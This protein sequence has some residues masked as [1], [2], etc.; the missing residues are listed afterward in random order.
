MKPKLDFNTPVCLIKDL[1]NAIRHILEKNFIEVY[2]EVLL[3]DYE[4]LTKLRNMGITNCDKFV[5]W[6]DSHS[7][8]LSI[9][10]QSEY[11]DIRS[12]FSNEWQNRLRDSFKDDYISQLEKEL[13]SEIE[14][15]NIW[16]QRRYILAKDVLLSLIDKDFS[17]SE[18]IQTVIKEA[19][20]LY[21]FHSSLAVKYADALI[22]EL[23]KED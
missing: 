13:P 5:K 17:S 11:D 18:N 20:D 9:L 14:K 8:D 15:D 1:S 21:K 16:K 4:N 7:D 2:G 19:G 12:K 23:R 3:L 22:E 6:K 10:M